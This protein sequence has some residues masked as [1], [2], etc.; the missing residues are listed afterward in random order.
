MKIEGVEISGQRIA[1]AID[2]TYPN[3][4]INLAA[5]KKNKLYNYLV[6]W[7]VR[8]ATCDTSMPDDAIGG[9]R[10]KKDFFGTDYW[11]IIFSEGT[12]DPT[13]YW[14]QNPMSDAKAYGGTAW[15]AEGQYLY[16]KGYGSFQGYP[17]FAP[18]NPV[19]VYRWTPSAKQ[20]SLSK[21][22]QLALSNAFESMK[23]LGQ[24]KISDSLS[25]LIHR[26]WSPKNLYKDSA[27]CQVFADNGALTKLT[28]WASEHIKI[29]GKN[30]F[31]YTLLTK[32]QFTMSNPSFTTSNTIFDLLKF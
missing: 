27:G 4:I 24:V 17:F 11:E 29:Y 3:G 25:V 16:S 13:P 1:N 14:L 2:Y 20:I 18:I 28:K 12:T 10:L 5:I 6:L 7:G 15:V 9:I 8:V 26:S 30:S 32:E 23:D 19:K 31:A 22:N 21:N